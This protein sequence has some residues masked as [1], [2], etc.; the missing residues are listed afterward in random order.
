MRIVFM[1]YSH[2]KGHS[3]RFAMPLPCFTKSSQRKI[4]R[5]LGPRLQKRFLYTLVGQGISPL[6]ARVS[7]VPLHPA[8]INLVARLRY[9]VV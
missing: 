5:L 7:R 3:A 4:F 1:N 8:P 9:Q 2:Y 6:I